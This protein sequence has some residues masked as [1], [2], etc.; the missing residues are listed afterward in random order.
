[1][2]T[3]VQQSRPPIYLVPTYSEW[4]GSLATIPESERRAFI[5]E[6]LRPKYMLPIFGRFFFP[7]IIK[8]DYETPEAHKDLIREIST[9]QNSAIIFPRGFAKTT[10][11]KIDTIHDIVYGIEPVILYVAV[12]LTDAGFHFE[13]IK[14]ELEIN[15]ALREVYGNLVPKASRIGRKWTNKHIE[16]TNGVNLV[17]RGRNKGRGVNIK[18]RRPTKII[19]DDIED[20]EQVKS[21]V[22]RLKLANW[23]NEVIIPSLDKENGFVKMIGTVL[24]ESSEVLKFY[25]GNGGILR[26][27]IENGQSIWPEYWSLSD[28]NIMKIGGILSN[29]KKV[30]GLGS[31]GFNK[32]YM[33]DPKAD[34]DATIKPEWIEKALY[35][36]LPDSD[37][38]AAVIYIDPQA[39]EKRTADEY[40]IT[41]LYAKKRTSQRFI[42]EQEAGRVTQL[43]QAKNVVRMWLRHKR[44]VRAVGIEKVLNQTAVWQNVRDWKAGKISFNDANT[45]PAEIIPEEDRNIPIVEWDPRGKDKLAR[46]QV[47]EPDFERGEIHLRAEME[48]LRDQLQFF[49]IKIEN[50]ELDDRGDSVVG[51]L[52]MSYDYG[53]EQGGVSQSV[54][55]DYNTKQTNVVGD[56]MKRR[57]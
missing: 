22:Q 50:K 14:T 56:L 31:R 12:G 1:M 26:R 46:L 37:D 51:A 25:Q 17:A 10:W 24:H 3:A 11:E 57:F 27:A 8:G 42:V 32:E 4:L 48:A 41:C 35:S 30:K 5:V 52:E 54:G 16:T 21:P 18:N 39:G 43:E 15:D 29:G 28:L 13:S 20:D 2:P 6:T 33:N 36:L 19:I 49:A 9:R 7:H 53:L 45:K 23:L 55:K 44:R 40:A 47:F 38:Y 34:S